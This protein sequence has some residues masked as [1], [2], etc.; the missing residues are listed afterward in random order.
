MP[1]HTSVLPDFAAVV[2][3]A[4]EFVLAS[5]AEAIA[6]RG[7]FSIAL[8]GGST[9]KAL[10][11]QLA[12]CDADW[13]HWQVFWGDE[14]YVPNDHPDSNERMARQA[15][16]DQVPIPADQIHPLPTQ[17]GNPAIDAATAEADIRQSFQTSTGEWPQF[18]LVLLGLGD[19]GHT[20]SLFPG[21][22]ALQVQDRLVTV[23]DRDGQ[24]RLSFT[25]PLI[26]Q[27]RNILFLVSGASKQIAVQRALATNG[28]SQQTPARLIQPV[29]GELHWLL[30]REAAA[31]L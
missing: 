13:Q 14:R 8:S 18:D 1:I 11:Q 21:T 22:A 19:D 31:L 27:A 28:D 26:N 15:W 25:A 6:D 3:A 5:A 12:S 16:L 9:P 24:P 30:D 23:G 17:A 29:A 4:Q 2:N 20:A 10:Y 7:Q